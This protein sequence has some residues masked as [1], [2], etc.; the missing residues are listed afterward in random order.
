MTITVMQVFRKLGIAH[1]PPAVSWAVGSRIAHKFAREF[2]HQPP[3]DNAPK[4]NGAGSH[5]FAHYPDSYEP[6]IVGAINEEMVRYQGNVEVQ[7]DFF[8]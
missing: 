1:P 6:A 3:K 7:Q 2:G 8:D 4:T 5:C